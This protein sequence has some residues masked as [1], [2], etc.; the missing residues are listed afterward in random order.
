MGA[1]EAK[2]Y[3]VRKTY[4][5]I[6]CI[7]APSKYIGDIL[8]SDPVLNGK[9]KVLHNFIVDKENEDGSEGETDPDDAGEEVRDSASL[10][11]LADYLKNPCETTNIIFVEG[12]VDARK[13]LTKAIDAMGG[14]FVIGEYDDRNKLDIQNYVHQNLKVKKGEMFDVV[15]V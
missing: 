3:H 1:V 14:Y 6:D 15:R 9:V 8:E 10:E 11:I 5:L 12:K 2:Y 13:K 7:I 4:D